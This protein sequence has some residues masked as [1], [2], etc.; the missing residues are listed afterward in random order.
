VG[1]PPAGF[2]LDEMLR[3]QYGGTIGHLSAEEQKKFYAEMKK[4]LIGTEN[5]TG[6]KMAPPEAPKKWYETGADYTKK[7][8]EVAKKLPYKKTALVATSPL[9]FPVKSVIDGFKGKKGALHKMNH[10]AMSPHGPQELADCAQ[11][12]KATIRFVIQS[13]RACPTVD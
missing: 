12:E 10:T 11:P 3:S 13:D 9:W 1:Y 7:S 2:L 4:T 6:Q 5:V 8:Y